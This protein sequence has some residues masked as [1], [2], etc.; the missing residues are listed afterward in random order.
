MSD[1]EFGMRKCT[2]FYALIVILGATV[3]VNATGALHVAPTLPDAQGDG[4]VSLRQLAEIDDDL[5]TFTDEEQRKFT[6]LEQVLGTAPVTADLPEP[7]DA[8]QCT[9]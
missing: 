7:T 5:A 4:A 2:A 6:V 9:P 3:S 8:G 1:M